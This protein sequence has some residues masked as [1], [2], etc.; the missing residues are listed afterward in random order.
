[1]KTAL[2]AASFAFLLFVFVPAPARAQIVTTPYNCGSYWSSYP[3]SASQYANYPQTSYPYYQ[4][5]Y[6]AQ[7]SYQYQYYPQ[8]SYPTYPTYPTYP[9]YQQN[10]PCGYYQYGCAQAPAIY[11][12]VPNSATPGTTITVYGS[13][14]SDRNN[15]VRVGNGVIT[16]LF[17]SDGKTLSFVLPTTLSGFNSQYATPGTYNVTVTNADGRTS[18]SVSFTIPGWYYTYPTNPVWY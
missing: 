11:S 14:F 7:P 1:M 3:C 10:Y 18:N 2:F 13:G 17:S 8:Y 4:Q 5:N 6:Y 9:S 16:N 12:I 15:S